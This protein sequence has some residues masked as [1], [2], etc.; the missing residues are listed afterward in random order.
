M[1]MS[2]LEWLTWSTVLAA[3]VSAL[4]LAGGDAGLPRFADG[5][6]GPGLGELN[7]D[8]PRAG[9]TPAPVTL[10]PAPAASKPS[11][12]AGSGA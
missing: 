8:P 10:T 5:V 12:P 11:A 9:A 1:K 4:L 7:F 3:V 6:D 2:V